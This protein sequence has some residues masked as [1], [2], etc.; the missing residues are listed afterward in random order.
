[1]TYVL[2]FK[3]ENRVCVPQILGFSSWA[4]LQVPIVLDL[5]AAVRGIYLELLDEAEGRSKDEAEGRSKDGVGRATFSAPAL[6]ESR[7]GPATPSRGPEAKAKKDEK[8]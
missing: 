2:V 6:Q 8:S 4:L 7:E 1:M 5:P 3:D